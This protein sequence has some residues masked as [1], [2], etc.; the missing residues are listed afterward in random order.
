MGDSSL[1]AAALM[2]AV[3]SPSESVI[4]SSIREARGLAPFVLF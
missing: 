1:S 2:I 4:G 3:I